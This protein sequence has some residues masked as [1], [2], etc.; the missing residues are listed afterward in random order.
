MQ[1]EPFTVVGGRR[2]T[3][4]VPVAR[5]TFAAIVG[6]FQ[7]SAGDPQDHAVDDVP[8]ESA[9]VP[10]R[11]HTLPGLEPRPPGAPVGLS[12]PAAALAVISRS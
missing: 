5:R 7:E 9:A 12:T 6:H 10:N 3:S 8:R 2:F 4:S 1:Q 11:F